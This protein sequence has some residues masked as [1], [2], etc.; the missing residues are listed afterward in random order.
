MY[1]DAPAFISVFQLNLS[2]SPFEQKAYNLDNM[3]RL[4][5]QDYASAYLLSEFLCAIF[6]Q[7]YIAYNK[8]VELFA[9]DKSAA[10]QADFPFEP[11]AS[12]MS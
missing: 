7:T 1:T 6:R 11:C 4:A 5:S 3:Q 12:V 9:G 8:Q 10:G 2:T